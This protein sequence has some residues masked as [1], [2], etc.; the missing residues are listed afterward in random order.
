VN[1]LVECVQERKH[2]VVTGALAAP[3]I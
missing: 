1:D 3:S 2:A